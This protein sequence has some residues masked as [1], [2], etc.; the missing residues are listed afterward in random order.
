MR[1]PD[2]L[3]LWNAGGWKL[4]RLQKAWWAVFFQIWQNLETI[5]HFQLARKSQQTT[6]SCLL[7]RNPRIYADNR[8][9][10]GKLEIW[11]VTFLSG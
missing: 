7:R 9:I 11:I 6:Y 10:R 3:H 8:L 4:A 5:R 1:N 2:C